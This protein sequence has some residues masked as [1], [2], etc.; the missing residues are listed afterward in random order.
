MP[1]AMS[2]RQYLMNRD[3]SEHKA[4][5]D[6]KQLAIF[7]RLSPDGTR[8]LFGVMPKPEKDKRKPPCRELVVLDI[9]YRKTDEGRGRADQRRDPGLLLVARW[10]AHR[11]HLEATSRRRSQWT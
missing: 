7:G 3:G 5:T 6:D 1:E 10:Q 8:A 9:A 11:L 2:A 4:L